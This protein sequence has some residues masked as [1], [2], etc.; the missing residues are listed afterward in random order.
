MARD[1]SDEPRVPKGSPEGGRWTSGAGAAQKF[2]VGLAKKAG[3]TVSVPRDHHKNKGTYAGPGR[4]SKAAKA[5]RQAAQNQ[6]H[7]ETVDVLKP[8]VDHL[9]RTTA[10]GV[11]GTLLGGAAGLGHAALAA[12]LGVDSRTG[13][14]TGFGGMGFGGNAKYNPNFNLLDQAIAQGQKIPLS[15]TGT[16]THKLNIQWATVTKNPIY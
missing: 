4:P 3:F 14:S 7:H 2:A 16:K 10:L 13:R 1:V 6:G 11:G 8:H 9:L 5:A 15:R 12:K